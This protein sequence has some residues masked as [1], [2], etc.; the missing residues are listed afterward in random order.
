ME[1]QNMDAYKYH[2][3]R[4]AAEF[5]RQIL[6]VPLEYPVHPGLPEGFRDD[7]ARL[8][9]WAKAVYLDMARAP[10]AYGLML[11]D[12]AE[13]DH[14]LARDSYRTIHR[15]VDTLNAL[16]LS[17]EV[18]NH[19]LRVD[20]AK[21]RK[22]IKS[23]SGVP[24][25]GQLLAKFCDHGLIISNLKGGTIARNA[26]LFTVESPGDP[27]LIDTIKRYCEYWKTVDRFRSK[28][29]PKRGEWI[30]ISPYEFHHHFYRFDYKITADLENLPFSTWVNDEADYQLYDEQ[31]KRFNEAFNL[32]SLRYD[33]LKFDGEYHYKGK[34]IA[35]VTPTGFSAL[36][37]PNFML[38]LKLKGM[39]QYMELV[40]SLPERIQAPLT[41][42]SCRN[43]GFQGAT[44]EHC[45][46]RLRWTLDGVKH[47]G[48]AFW[49]FF[50]DDFRIEAVPIY[51][52]LLEKE[53][54]LKRKAE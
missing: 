11:V 6:P 24:R 52:E 9:E 15:F 18:E 21:F 20:A 30:K 19:C 49:C 53:Y 2:V 27:R 28:D 3:Q 10:E 45:K 25:Y 40:E 34:R 23:N 35:R 42:S 32:A 39:D 48:C 41:R 14:N 47:T 43:C 17:G 44:A 5:A 29:N 4:Q 7:F 50:F 13:T 37:T 12:I 36:G 16:A 22:A 38:S 8:C 51:F 33:G 26:V 46:F 54:G 1:P 31:L